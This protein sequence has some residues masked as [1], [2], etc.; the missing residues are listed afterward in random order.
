MR[1]GTRADVLIVNGAKT[2]V[3]GYGNVQNQVGASNADNPVFKAVLYR[4]SA[5]AGS[6][7]SDAGIPASTIARMYHSV[8]TLMP[9]GAFFIAGSNPND[10]VTYGGTYPT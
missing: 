9:N 6:R 8:C 5:P 3:A 10:A 7:F 4:P 2:G 1:L